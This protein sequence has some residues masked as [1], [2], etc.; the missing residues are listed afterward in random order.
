[1]AKLS[2]LTQTDYS[3]G[4]N[5]TKSDREIDRNE[6]SLL[7]NW[8]ITFE[9]QLVRRDGLLQIGDTLSNEIDGMTYYERA[10]GKDILVVEGGKLRYLNSATWDSIDTGFTDNEFKDFATCPLNN[11][12][13][14]SSKSD[15]LHSWDRASVVEDSSLTDLGAGVPHGN[16][17]RWHKNHMFT[18]NSVTV[19]GT[20]YKHR[21]YWSAIGDPDTWDTANDFIQIPGNGETLAIADLGDNLAIFKSRSIQYLSGWG[22]SDWRITASS[23]N[24]TNVDENVGI[25]GAFA[26]TRVGNE[27]WY[28]DDEGNIRRL[29]QTDFDPFRRDIISTKLRGTLNGLNKTKLD[30]VRAWTHNDKVYFS[31]PNGSSSTNDLVLVFDI[32]AS[33]RTGSEAWTTYT[34]WE[35]TQWLSYPT[36]GTPDLYM[37]DKNGK[38][39]KYSGDDDDGTAVDARWDGRDDDLDKVEVWKRFKF[40]Y[41]T[42]A[43]SAATSV[44]VHAATDNGAFADLGD[45]VLATTGGTLGPSGTFELGPTGTTAILGGATETEFRFFYSSGGG[46]VT[47]KRLKHS[48]RHEVVGKKPTINSFSSHFKF[49][50][51]R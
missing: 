30:L 15:T 21:L 44:E 28:M 17:I 11:K 41:I 29:F 3:G 35:P 43:S 19:S 13:Y 5:D 33:R 32:N 27:I 9:G 6:A 37:S 50:D 34:G 4:L 47:G 38:I 10:T 2:T 22:D 16:V 36:S 39:Y 20:T 8:D 48:I 26:H 45:L 51:L 31:V 40:G 25:A 1:M 12:L 18:T 46:S 7:R 42:G 49:R 24:V 23:S 14:I